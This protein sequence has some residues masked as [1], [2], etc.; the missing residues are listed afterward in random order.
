MIGGTKRL[1]EARCAVSPLLSWCGPVIRCQQ[2]SIPAAVQNLRGPD[3]WLVCTTAAV[4]PQRAQ[5]G[6]AAALTGV[7][8][9][10]RYKRAGVRHLLTEYLQDGFELAGV[11]FVNPFEAVNN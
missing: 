3:C 9:G 6:D 2:I 7:R 11:R 1:L 8:D 5:N 10:T 4:P